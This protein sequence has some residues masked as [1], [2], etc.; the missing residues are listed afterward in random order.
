MKHFFNYFSVQNKLH[1]VLIIS[2]LFSLLVSCYDLNI[3]RVAQN[4]DKRISVADDTQFYFLLEDKDVSH[5]LRYNEKKRNALISKYFK[6]GRDGSGE[7]RVLNYLNTIKLLFKTTEISDISFIFLPRVYPELLS[8]GNN[9]QFDS[10]VELVYKNIKGKSKSYVNNFVDY[11]MLLQ[12]V[13]DLLGTEFKN[14]EKFPDNKDSFERTKSVFADVAIM[15]S[16]FNF[17]YRFHKVVTV[18]INGDTVKKENPVCKQGEEKDR[19]KIEDTDPVE[20][21]DDYKTTLIYYLINFKGYEDIFSFQVEDYAHTPPPPSTL[22]EINIKDYL[23]SDVFFY[24]DNILE[25]EK[26]NNIEYVIKKFG[27]ETLI[28][29]I[30]NED[31]DL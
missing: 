11:S 23:Y 30:G 17:L 5:Y 20:Y 13:F 15:S 19:C 10:F 27:L 14:G 6:K 28:N 24:D 4:I 22:P 25:P 29:E 1:Y 8:T 12:K 26:E 9:I 7:T 2:I 21:K 31:E 16:I 3:F 18:D